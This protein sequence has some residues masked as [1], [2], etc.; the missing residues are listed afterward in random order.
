MPL[1]RSACP[2][3]VLRGWEVLSG[4]TERG[5]KASPRR[6]LLFQSTRNGQGL[7]PVGFLLGL[8]WG[9]NECLPIALLTAPSSSS[10][11][12]HHH[13]STPQKGL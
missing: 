13:Q 1:V 5:N 2:G 9:C 3:I 12:S 4:L 10:V 11:H 6:A 7:R 8:S